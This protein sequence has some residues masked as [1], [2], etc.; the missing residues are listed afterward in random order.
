MHKRKSDIN[1][2][3][4]LNYTIRLRSA[5]N[6]IV[7]PKSPP[8][9][10]FRYGDKY[11]R[12]HRET[13]ARYRHYFKITRMKLSTTVSLLFSCKQK[14]LKRKHFNASI[15]NVNLQPINSYKLNDLF[16]LENL[17]IAIEM[18]AIKTKYLTLTAKR[19]RTK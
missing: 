15:E 14:C 13:S 1:I 3:G 19:Q 17:S 6:T 5:C 12:L 7:S 4:S 8:Q 9:Q 2:F 18:A 11:K 10:V 16:L